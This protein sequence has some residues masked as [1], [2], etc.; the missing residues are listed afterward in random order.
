VLIWFPSRSRGLGKIALGEAVSAEPRSRER[1]SA[2]ERA[3]LQSGASL[4][5]LVRQV[6][7]SIGFARFETASGPAGRTE[8]TSRVV[9]AHYVIGLS[10]VM[11]N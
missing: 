2:A 10:S 1:M 8:S 7:H 3:L 5:W 9:V 6:V 11:R 4:G